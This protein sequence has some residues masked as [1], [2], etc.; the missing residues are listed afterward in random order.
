MPA[1]GDVIGDGDIT[2][3]RGPAVVLDL[4]GTVGG[5]IAI[6]IVHPLGIGDFGMDHGTD[7]DSG[8]AATEFENGAVCGLDRLPAG[9]VI[10]L[11]AGGHR[12]RDVSILVG[13]VTQPLGDRLHRRRRALFIRCRGAGGDG[14]HRDDRSNSSSCSHIR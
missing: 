9:Q 7:V 3:L 1:R 8:M 4:I 10:R 11:A 13:Q 6:G 5:G 14:R 2:P 12:I